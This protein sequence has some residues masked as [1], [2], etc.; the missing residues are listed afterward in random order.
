MNVQILKKISS[1]PEPLKI[2]IKAKEARQR[3]PDWKSDSLMI[4]FYGIASY[5]WKYWGDELKRLDIDWPGFEKCLSAWKE[6]FVLWSRD[7]IQW[8][9]MIE[10]IRSHIPRY[11]KWLDRRR[12]KIK[13]GGIFP[14]RE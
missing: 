9:E 3:D 8:K 7:K 12:G 6:D 13:E 2:K 1:P 11:K 14:L 4:W 10:D 5:L